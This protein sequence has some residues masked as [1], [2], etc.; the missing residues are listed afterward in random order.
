M[1][2]AGVRIVFS[3]HYGR[4]IEKMKQQ[5]MDIRQ[6]HKELRRDARQQRA[7]CRKHTRGSEDAEAG[8][9]MPASKTPRHEL[10]SM[11]RDAAAMVRSGTPQRFRS[12]RLSDAT[13]AA[14][15]AP[16]GASSPKAVRVRKIV[17]SERP[18]SV[19]VPVANADDEFDADVDADAD[20]NGKTDFAAGGVFGTGSGAS[21]GAGGGGMAGHS[22]E[23]GATAGA[24]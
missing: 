14:G 15:R 12:T 23:A 4:T 3:F 1:G 24:V 17:A 2:L 5:N 16:R 7:T 18:P 19:L 11:L 21:S 9:G 20:T 22:Q 13:D 10:R 6:L 8:D